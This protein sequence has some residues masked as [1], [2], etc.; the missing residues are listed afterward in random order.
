MAHQPKWGLAISRFQR[1]KWLTSQTSWNRCSE[2]HA[3][4]PNARRP[5]ADPFKCGLDDPKGLGAHTVEGSQFG[6]ACACKLP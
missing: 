6:A 3:Q 4:R 5:I 1:P 2:Q